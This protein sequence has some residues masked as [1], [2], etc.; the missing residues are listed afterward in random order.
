MFTKLLEITPV[1]WVALCALA[2]LAVVVLAA[3]KGS[4]QRAS[5]GMLAH[6]A[7]CIALA[8]VLSYVRLYRMPQGGSITPASML[9]LIAFSFAYGVRPGLLAGLAYGLLHMLQGA[10]IIHPAQAALDYPLAYAMLG[11][12]GLTRG[13]RGRFGLLAGLLI[14]ALGRLACATLS[15]IIIFHINGLPEGN[16]VLAS[17]LY[18]LTYLGPDALLCAL[19]CLIPGIGAMVRRLA[20]PPSSSG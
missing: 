17:L 4:S 5:T 15:G 8:F 19:V 11:L 10:W 16:V 9:P 12:A 7:V 3:R 6:G 14:G 2:L 1:T 13:M 18:N 20:T